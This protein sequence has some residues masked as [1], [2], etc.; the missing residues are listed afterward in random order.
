[1]QTDV[2]RKH[3]VRVEEPTEI[4]ISLEAKEV[5]CPEGEDSGSITV[6]SAE[7]GAGSYIYAIDGINYSIDTAFTSLLAGAYIVSVQDIEGCITTFPIEVE[8]PEEIILELDDEQF[9]ELGESIDLDPF[10]IN[11]NLI[12][13]WNGLTTGRLF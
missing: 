7:G 9:I 11:N 13:S 4:L 12:Y 3:S 10:V 5:T 8:A 1:M 6:V 2:P